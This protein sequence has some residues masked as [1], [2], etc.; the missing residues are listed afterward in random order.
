MFLLDPTEGLSRDELLQR[1]FDVQMTPAQRAVV[2]ENAQARG[3]TW[4]ELFLDVFEQYDT[5]MDDPIK[6]EEWPG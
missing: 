6:R 5:M 3:C 1:I 4:Q 2:L